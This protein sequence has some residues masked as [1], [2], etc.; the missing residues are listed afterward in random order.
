MKTES[1]IMKKDENLVVILKEHEQMLNSSEL[2][3]YQD[4]ELK[5]PNQIEFMSDK[6]KLS[7]IDALSKELNLI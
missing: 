7:Y 4:I 6:A 3:E 5:K 1:S 2:K